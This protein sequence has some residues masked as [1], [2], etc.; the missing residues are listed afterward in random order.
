VGKDFWDSKHWYSKTLSQAK[1]PVLVN[2]SL[3]T[4]STE[5]FAVTECESNHTKWTNTVAYYKEEKNSW[6]LQLPDKKTKDEKEEEGNAED[7]LHDAKYT[8]S[9]GGQKRFGTYSKTGLERYGSLMMTIKN[10]AKTNAKAVADFEKKFLAKL[11]ED[12]E[13]GDDGLPSRKKGGKKRKI[14]GDGGK[15][16]RAKV[17]FVCDSDDSDDEGSIGGDSD[18]TTLEEEV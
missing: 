6:G 16:K 8:S 12:D 14:A 15:K 13:V 17:V 3:F 9:S 7:P 4:P 10:N 1:V 2:K 5:A 18:A 11:K